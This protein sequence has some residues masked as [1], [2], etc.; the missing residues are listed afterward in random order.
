MEDYLDSLE[1]GVLKKKSSQITK[2]DVFNLEAHAYKQFKL[3]FHRK[4]LSLL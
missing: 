4:I 3:I 2:S 1:L